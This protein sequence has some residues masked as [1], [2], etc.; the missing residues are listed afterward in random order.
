MDTAR[1]LFTQTCEQLEKASIRYCVLRDPSF[2][3]DHRC[4]VDLLVD[5]TDLERFSEAVRDLQFVK[6]SGWGR[7]PHHFYVAYAAGRNAWLKLDV[8]TRL[9]FGYGS[10]AIHTDLA[11]GCLARRRQVY[12]CFRPTPHDELLALLLHAILD[13]RAFSPE[14]AA[15]VQSLW[16]Q[17]QDFSV[18]ADLLA[19]VWPGM[20]RERLSAAIEAGAWNDLLAERRRIEA[21]L[22]GRHR[23]GTHLR[24]IR[25]RLLRKADRLARFVRPQTLSIAVVAPDGAG[26][27]TLIRSLEQSFYGSVRAIY[28][29]LYNRDAKAP[30]LP[31]P[32]LAF[33][34]RMLTQW[35]RYLAARL[36][37]GRGRFVVFDRY[38]YDALLPSRRAQGFG[39][40][41]RRALLAYACPAPDLLVM[42]DA[43]GSV[44]FDRKG[45][46]SADFLEQQRQ[47]YLVLKARLPQMVVV[48]ATREPGEVCRNVT[49]LIWQRYG[50][51]LESGSRA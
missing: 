46:H 8:V 32:G 11:E 4:E 50:A 10:H 28:M 22:I 48:D 27:S 45:E 42:L 36:H 39:G 26:K 12:G 19:P 35:K 3:H 24:R 38:T 14:R 20:T 37:L 15:R 51:R 44:L 43:P 47:A 13:K 1:S 31:L 34:G 17:I 30:R 29:G 2:W 33:A 7:A 16:A 5:P 25:D 41:L 23:M 18:L 49:Q 9:A 21:A 40:K 6:L